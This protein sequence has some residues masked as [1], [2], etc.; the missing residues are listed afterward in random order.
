MFAQRRI[1]TRACASSARALL[2]LGARFFYCLL[3]F[4]QADFSET[5]TCWGISGTGCRV[6]FTNPALRNIFSYSE[7]LYASPE[8]VLASIIRLNAAAVGGV[9]RSSLGTNSSVMALP[10][11]VNAAWTR[12]INFSQVG[13]SK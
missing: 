3:L 4:L 6:D 12:R 10:P 11:G 1:A 8:S 7:K 13:I 9:T 2:R 5:I